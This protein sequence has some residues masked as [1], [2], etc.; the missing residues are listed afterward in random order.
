MQFTIFSKQNGNDMK[1][2]VAES[3]VIDAIAEIC[4][5][6]IHNLT[7]WPRYSAAY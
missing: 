5:S 3:I 1:M 4:Q 2:E 7:Q 6:P